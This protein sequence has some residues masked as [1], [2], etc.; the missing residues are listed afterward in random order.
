MERFGTEVKVRRV[1]AG[2]ARCGPARSSPARHVAAGGAARICVRRVPAWLGRL[3]SVGVARPGRAMQA[4][5][6]CA[7]Q[8]GPGSARQAWIVFA[9]ET[10]RIHQTS[11]AMPTTTTP[12]TRMTNTPALTI[13]DALILEAAFI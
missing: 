12:K 6:V 5:R 8:D 1:L 4:R 9:L 10:S 7:T 11:M 3:G 13:T 2:D